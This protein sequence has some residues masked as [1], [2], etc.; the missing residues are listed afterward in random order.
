MFCE[1]ILH[2]ISPLGSGWHI[3][4]ISV[5]RGSLMG[6]AKVEKQMLIAV[7]SSCPDQSRG[8]PW[9]K[10]VSVSCRCHVF[11]NMVGTDVMFQK[12]FTCAGTSLASL[13]NRWRLEGNR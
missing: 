7:Y 12:H 8:I 10:P 6:G 4:E 3:L 9:P 2:C 5:L 13:S 1:A 11:S